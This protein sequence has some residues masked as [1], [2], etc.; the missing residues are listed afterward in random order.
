MPGAPPMGMPQPPPMA[1]GLGAGSPFGSLFV[2][3]SVD[4]APE[5]QMVDMGIRCLRTALKTPGFQKS[6]MGR[7]NAVIR[8]LTNTAETLLSH[9]TSGPKSGAPTA[10]ESQMEP[11]SGNIRSSDADSAPNTDQI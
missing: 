7:V 3:L 11:E 9:Y 1:G 4:L 6:S 8:E 2:D 10:A 5:W